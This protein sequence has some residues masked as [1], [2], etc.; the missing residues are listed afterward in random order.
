MSTNLLN[1][2]VTEVYKYKD[3]KIVANLSLY[4][5]NMASQPLETSIDVSLEKPIVHRMS[6]YKLTIARFRVPL[7]NIFPSFD[8][9][10]LLIQITFTYNGTPYS[11]SVTVNNVFYTISEF[12]NLVNGITFNASNGIPLP[13][14]T[15]P[16][17]FYEDDFFYFVFP[18]QFTGCVSLNKDLYYYL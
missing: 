6:D 15:P 13:Q 17:I 1:S 12:I 11:S 8:L 4:N 9:R 3:D 16:Y 7:G 18:T 14:N 5:P 2:I 10:N